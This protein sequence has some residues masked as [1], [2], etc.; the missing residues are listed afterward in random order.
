MSICTETKF[1]I[2]EKNKQDLQNPK[3]TPIALAIFSNLTTPIESTADSPE[4]KARAELS[5]AFIKYVQVPAIDLLVKPTVMCKFG[6]YT[7]NELSQPMSKHKL[8]S[9][10]LEPE[11]TSQHA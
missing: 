3:P 6:C 10:T 2:P 9:K 8:L 5:Y 1:P 7:N 11:P 4:T